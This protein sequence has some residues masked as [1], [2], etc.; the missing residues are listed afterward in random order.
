M[1]EWQFGMASLNPRWNVSGTYMQVLPRFLST[2][3]DG[4]DEKEFLINYFDSFEEMLS[5]IF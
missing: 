2:D 4:S 5:A 3:A 1:T